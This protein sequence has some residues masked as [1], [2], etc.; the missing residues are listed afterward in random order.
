MIIYKSRFVIRL[1]LLAFLA[2][3]S[4]VTQAQVEGFVKRN[5]DHLYIDTNGN[6]IQDSDEPDYRMIGFNSTR[7]A[8][9]TDANPSTNGGSKFRWGDPVE[10]QMAMNDIKQ[11]GANIF[12][13][14]G[15]TVVGANKKNGYNPAV[16]FICYR[17]PAI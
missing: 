12:H 11:L 4:S 7:L 13:G 17:N 5:I 6:G 16:L 1:L 8:L 10:Y 2:V 14:G 15:L 3:S 9:Q